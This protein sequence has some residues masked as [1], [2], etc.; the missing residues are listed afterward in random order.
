MRPDATVVSEVVL[1]VPVHFPP[2]A[3]RKIAAMIR[4]A[5]KGQ[6]LPV[7]LRDENLFHPNLEELHSSLLIEISS[8]AF[9]RPKLS[10][11]PARTHFDGQNPSV[12][13]L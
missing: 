1:L 10:S 8:G 9:K 3:A 13:A 6:L 2:Q 7:P 4:S 12:S 5:M 11:A